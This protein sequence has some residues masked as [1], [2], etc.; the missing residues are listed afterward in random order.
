EGASTITQQLVKLRLVGNELS[1]DR[2][3]REA[4]LAFDVERHFSKQQILEMYLNSVFFGNS[5]WGS[6]AASKIYFHK[7]TRDLDLAQ[8]SMLA[9]LVRGPT[10]YNPLI[11]WKSAKARQLVVLQAM[12][13]SE[14]ATQAQADAAYTEDISPPKH[15]F[16]PTNSILAA[17]FVSYVTSQLI[18]QFGTDLTYT[19]GL[20]VVTT[21]NAK[22][23]SIA[24]SAV[25]GTLRKIA[26]RNVTQGALV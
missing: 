22:L 14:Y 18:A 12:V 13:R 20:Q 6:A 24:Q 19:G 16:T 7:A 9:G 26:W 1:I 21:L 4:L 17:G 15:M 2:K 8:A 11:N 3:L 25:T 10:I 23:Q 5:A